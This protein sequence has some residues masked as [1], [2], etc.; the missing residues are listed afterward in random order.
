MRHWD[1]E[2]NCTGQDSFL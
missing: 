1:Q 2:M